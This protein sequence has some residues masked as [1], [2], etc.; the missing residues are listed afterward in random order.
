MHA[1]LKGLWEI[2]FPTMKGTNSLPC[3]VHAGCASVGLSL[4]FLFVFC[5]MVSSINF[6]WI[7]FVFLCFG[8]KMGLTC[9]CAKAKK[10]VRFFFF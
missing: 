5:V 2:L 10:K 7:F 9:A 4:A 1:T 8:G 6:Y 3:L